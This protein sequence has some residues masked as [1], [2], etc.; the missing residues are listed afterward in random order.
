MPPSPDLPGSGR[1][2][3]GTGVRTVLVFSEARGSGFKVR[4]RW[5][6]CRMSIEWSA[7]SLYG[8][9]TLGM[10]TSAALFVRALVGTLR[11]RTEKRDAPMPEC[12]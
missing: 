4:N 3:T 12:C 9:V 2:E 5:R 1:R 10:V 8:I 11:E 7:L 6:I